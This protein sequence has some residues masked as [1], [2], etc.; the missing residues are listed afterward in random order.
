MTEE[1]YQQC[2]HVRYCEYK[3]EEPN[4]VLCTDGNFRECNIFQKITTIREQVNSRSGE[5]E[6]NILAL[7]T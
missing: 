6:R 5:R 7:L 2:P 4:N 3:P 1:K